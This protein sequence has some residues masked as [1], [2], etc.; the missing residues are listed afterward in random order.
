MTGKLAM[1]GEINDCRKSLAVALP[2]FEPDY[3]I[4]GVIRELVQNE[5]ETI[6]VVDDGSESKYQEHFL[7]ASNYPQVVVLHHDV[8]RG[9]GR[10]LKT[11]F[12][13]VLQNLP[14]VKGVITIDGDGQHLTED[15]LACGN[16]MLKETNKVILGCRDFSLPNVPP[17]SVAGNR[18][19]SN[20]FRILFGIHLSDI[21]IEIR[22]TTC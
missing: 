17:R 3:K 15:I 16:E 18:F 11:A 4:D 6:I 13:Y 22:K 14:E 5:F 9:K 10:A 21:S 19:T 1:A 7:K 8:N 12:Q 2:S 20:A